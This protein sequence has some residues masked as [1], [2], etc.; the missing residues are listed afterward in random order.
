MRRRETTPQEQGG[1][2]RNSDKLTS[3]GASVR[4][5][6]TRPVTSGIDIGVIKMIHK[7]WKMLRRY[8]HIRPEALH[9]LVAARTP[10]PANIF[11]AE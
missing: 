6:E 7:G 9:S 10:Y 2:P 11:A 5:K 3:S 1:H 8:T 4:T